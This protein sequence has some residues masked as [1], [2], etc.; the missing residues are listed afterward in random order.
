MIKNI[1]LDMGNV[2]CRWDV[3]HIVKSLTDQPVMQELIK[4]R[5]FLSKQWHLLDAGTISLQQ[6]EMEMSEH[7]SDEEK[8]MIHYA[9]WHW[10]D[11]FD[12]YNVMEKYIK[13]WKEK[14]YFIF[15]LSNCSLQFYDYFQN[16]SIFTLFDGYYISAKHQLLKP[17]KEIYMDFLKQYH[18]KAENCLFV[19]DIE[20]NVKGAMAVGMKAVVY[21]GNPDIIEK[22]LIL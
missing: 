7:L 21:H 6:A 20:D 10:H 15:L 16:K 8:E 4:T 19:D 2:C 13:K 12:Q 22:M 17:N 11:F 14:G 1:V 18:L 5:V 3:N 9:L